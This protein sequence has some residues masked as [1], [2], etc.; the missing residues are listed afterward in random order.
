ME[1]ELD[2]PLKMYE[3]NCS[4]CHWHFGPDKCSQRTMAEDVNTLVAEGV[5]LL[6]EIVALLKNREL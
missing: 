2:C 1:R 3:G 6:K 4:K 5:P